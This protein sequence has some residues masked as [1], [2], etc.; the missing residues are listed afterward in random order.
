MTLHEVLTYYRKANRISF[1]VLVKRT[2]I[3][4]STLQKI[5]TGVTVDPGFEVVRRIACGLGIT[6]DM[7]SVAT[8]NT[9][10]L[11][12]AALDVAQKY[13]RLDSHGQHIV[14]VVLDEE[15]SRIQQYGRLNPALAAPTIEELERNAASLPQNAADHDDAS[16][17]G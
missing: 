5:F 11:S 4:K 12:T 14:S 2:G 16:A 7:V 13:D 10:G 17:I 15:L 6:V 8:Q 9:P 1:D 3:S